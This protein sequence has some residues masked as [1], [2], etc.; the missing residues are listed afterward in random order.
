M[1]TKVHKGDMNIMKK[2]RFIPVLAVAALLSACGTSNGSVSKPKFAKAGEEVRAEKFA[3]DFKSVLNDLDL[4]KEQLL[5]SKELK[6]SKKESV[7]GKHLRN[8]KAVETLS[9]TRAEKDSAKYDATNFVAVVDQEGSQKANSQHLNASE[10]IDADFTD[11]TQLQKIVYNDVDYLA[12]INETYKSI[13][14]VRNLSSVELS[15]A[16][17]SYVKSYVAEELEL[18]SAYY[19]IDMLENVDYLS[20]QDFKLYEAKNLFTLEAKMEYVFG[21]VTNGL[22]EYKETETIEYKVQ[23]E[24]KDNDVTYRYYMVNDSRCEYYLDVAGNPSA[25][26]FTDDFREGDVTELRTI[27]SEEVSYKDASVKLET[28]NVDPVDYV[29]YS[30]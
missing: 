14:L 25:E 5:K 20:L 22:L 2:L 30:A 15:V 26:Y 8:K 29:I 17:D 6:V 24:I 13:E 3:Q 28:K 1:S 4:S 27:R 10:V 12:T 7:N 18:Q 21:K 9:G 11:T 16:I 23:Y 19:M